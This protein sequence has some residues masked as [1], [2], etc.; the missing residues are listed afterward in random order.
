M[1]PA[2]LRDKQWHEVLTH[3]TDDMVKVH[4]AFLRHGGPGTTREVAQASGISLL[5]FRP[6]TTDLYKLG[7]VELVGTRGNEGLYAYR[8]SDQAH[9]SG[10]WRERA[11][12]RRR[13]SDEAP[14]AVERVGFITV[15]EAV[16][17]LSPAEQ[18]ALGAKLM[19]KWGHTGKTREA[20]AGAEQLSLLPA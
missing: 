1:T 9:A 13:A 3:V 11:D 12:L 10:A 4:G 8:S 15:E 20:T 18:A 16:N 7:L 5:T 19:G 2:D 6:R 14:A 17:S